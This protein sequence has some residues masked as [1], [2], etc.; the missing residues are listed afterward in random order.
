MKLYVLKVRA[1]FYN[2]AVFSPWNPWYDK[3]FG[4]I[5]RAKSKRH[6][7]K[8][9]SESSGMDDW[10]NNKYVS[11]ERLKDGGEAGIILEDFASA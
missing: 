7:R 6:A 3:A 1:E 8:M 9:A 4:Y 5:I 2:E 11:C 10:N